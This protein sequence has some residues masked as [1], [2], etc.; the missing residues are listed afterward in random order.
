MITNIIMFAIVMFLAVTL[1]AKARVKE[2]GEHF[3]DKDNSNALR[4]FWCLIIVLVHIPV[5]YQ[6]RIQDI[7]GS[8]AYIGV[9]FFFMT[10]AYGLC[11]KYARNKNICFWK[12][13]LLKLLIPCFLVNC[14][15]ALM[16]IVE[17]KEANIFTILNINDWV[18]W[19]IVCYFF[20]WLDYKF[21]KSNKNWITIVLVCVFSILIYMFKQQI[22]KATWCP[23]VI[24]FVWGIIL[25]YRKD[26]FQKKVLKNWVRKMVELFIVVITI[27]CCYLKFKTI[28]FWGDY[29]LKVLLGALIIG[30]ML[31]FNTKFCIGNKINEFLG[32]IS[33]EVYLIHG[34][35]FGVVATFIPN[36]ISGVF[37]LLSLLFTVIIAYILHNVGMWLLQ[38]CN[39]L[40]NIKN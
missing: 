37:I 13:R 19:L 1:L 36:S 3:F 15:S 2:S 35:V 29:I 22:N 6:N 26:Y 33:F 30:F 14:F 40:L 17:K 9:T 25:Y 11:L 23:E 18:V 21:V 5:L 12:N 31:V 34:V 39:K 28:Y 16:H 38:C 27:G 4:G 32:K 7:I 8:F 10:S 24:G 20:F